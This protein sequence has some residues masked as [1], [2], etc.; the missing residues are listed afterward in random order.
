M[1]SGVELFRAFGS[2]YLE[3]SDKANQQLDGFNK[4]GSTVGGILGKVGKAAAIGGAAVAGAAVIIGTKAVKAAGEFEKGMANV[5]TLLTGDFRPG[6]KN[7]QG[8]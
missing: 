8:T 1:A 3:G 4:K 6:L 2:V 7:C 5:A